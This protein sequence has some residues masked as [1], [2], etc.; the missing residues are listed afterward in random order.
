[1]KSGVQEDPDLILTFDDNADA[2]DV[3]SQVNEV[4]METSKEC[5]VNMYNCTVIRDK[6]SHCLLQGSW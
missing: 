1:M 2:N 3:M 4:V 5:N 6:T